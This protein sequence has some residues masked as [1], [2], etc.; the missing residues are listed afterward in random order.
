MPCNF[1]IDE[2]N[3]ELSKST[4]T[5]V[6][7]TFGCSW[8]YGVGV[9]YTNSMTDDEYTD[10]AWDKDICATHS[11]RGI[12]S[13]DIN[14]YNLN[15]AEGGSSNE[16][17]FRYARE[18]FTNCAFKDIAKNKD[19]SVLWAITSTAR[20]ELWSNIDNCYNTFKYDIDESTLNS[21]LFKETY[22]HSTEVK[23]L[24]ENMIV[25]N[26]FFKSLGINNIWVDT[27]NTHNYTIPINNLVRG[28]D[29][30][31][32]LADS[33]IKSKSYHLSSWRN[34]DLRV[35][36]LVKAGYINPISLHPTKKGHK[37]I[38]KILTPYIEQ[39]I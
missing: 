17:Q 34:D 24:S 6:L 21:L 37:K 9:N 22:N 36:V 23:K 11:F 2:K 10:S 25:W 19:I 16:R 28:G 14:A 15:I 31:T 30:M 4:K 1:D 38:A 5:K 39:L 26:G 18:I 29:L 20:N 27:F 7:I 13:K 32:Q 8:T 35:P 3:L 12:I 33:K